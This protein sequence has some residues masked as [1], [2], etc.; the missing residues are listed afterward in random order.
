LQPAAGFIERGGAWEFGYNGD[1]DLLFFTEADAKPWT[2]DFSGGGAL[3]WLLSCLSLEGEGGT[4]LSRQDQQTLLLVFILQNFFPALRRT[5]IIPAALGPQGSGKSTMLR[6][7]GTLLQGPHFDVTG[8]SANR[9]GAFVAAVSNRVI[10]ALDNADSRIPWLEDAL[11]TYATAL[12]YRLR[13]LYTTNEEVSYTPRA[14]LL[15]SSRDP[16]F[17]RPDVAERLLPLTFKRPDSYLPES[18]LF[19]ELMKRRSSILG[20]LL[21]RAGKVAD[22]LSGIQLPGLPFRMADY[23]SFGWAVSAAVSGEEDWVGLLKKLESSQ[24]QFAGES[25][26]LIL[27]LRMLLDSDGSIGPID[28]GELYR[29]CL[30][31]AGEQSLPFPK[32]AQ[33][34]GKHLTNMRRV[35]EIELGATFAEERA[36]G[37][38][39]FVT[40]RRRELQK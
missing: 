26:S 37:G 11:A 23:A 40:I 30:K 28:V 2:P 22:T 32:T 10:V 16:H 35:V 25:D 1:D 36:G 39:R 21:T 4:G 6:M 12:R 19:A 14:I 13:Q 33:G 17:R 7:V 27:V 20:E 29:Q 18:L 34:F 3:A 9:E 8:L 24:M 31:L 5:R 15:L 38:R